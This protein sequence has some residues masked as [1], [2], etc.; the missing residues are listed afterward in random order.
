MQEEKQNTNQHDKLLAEKNEKHKKMRSDGMKT[1]H[2]ICDNMR[3]KTA[4]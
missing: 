2:S 3:R 1:G 4:T